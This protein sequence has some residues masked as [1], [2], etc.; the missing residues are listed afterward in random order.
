MKRIE[1]LFI[2]MIKIQDTDEVLQFMAISGTCSGIGTLN[3]RNKEYHY[4][5]DDL[6]T[7][8]FFV[9]DQLKRSILLGKTLPEKFVHG[10]G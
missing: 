6:E 10:F 5:G 2:E 4:E 8:S 9:G 1:K 7:W 3:K